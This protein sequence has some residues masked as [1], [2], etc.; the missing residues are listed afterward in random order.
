M[1][2]KCQCIAAQ[3]QNGK[4][5]SLNEANEQREHYPQFRNYPRSQLIQY[6]QQDFACQDVTKETKS[7]GQ[8]FSHCISQMQRQECRTRADKMFKVADALFRHTNA[9]RAKRN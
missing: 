4:D 1:A 5:K 8:R 9:I 3:R 6:D 7:H 2:S